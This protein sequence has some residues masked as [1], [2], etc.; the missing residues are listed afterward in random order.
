M[1]ISQMRKVLDEFAALF[2]RS[3]R[4]LDAEALRRLSAVLEPANKETVS[5]TVEKLNG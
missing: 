3:G 2:E 4:V 5:K 1:K